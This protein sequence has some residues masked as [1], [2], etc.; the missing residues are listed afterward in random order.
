MK[1]N[2]KATKAL[3]VAGLAAAAMG[4]ALGGLLGTA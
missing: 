1:D 4:L 3:P 2:T